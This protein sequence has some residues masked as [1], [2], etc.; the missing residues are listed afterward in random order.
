MPVAVVPREV[1]LPSA[2]V[3]YAHCVWNEYRSRFPGPLVILPDEV[4]NAL[5]VRANRGDHELIRQAVKQ[6]DVRP[7]QVLIEVLIVEARSDRG[8]SLGT[9]VSVPGQPLSGGGTAGGSLRGPISAGNTVL[10]LM[11]LGKEK[12]DAVLRVAESSGRV[13]IVSRPVLIASNNVEARLL[14]GAQ[15]PFVQ[16]TRALPTEAAVRDQVVQYR[17]VG[18]KLTIR[19]TINQDGF[20]TLQVRQEINAATAEVQFDAPVISTREASTQ[21]LARDGQTIVIGGLRDEQRERS[22]AG[23]PILSGIPLLGGLFGGQSRRSTSVELFLFLTPRIIASDDD[24][25]GVT[26]PRLPEGVEP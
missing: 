13:R 22:R 8:F 15:R 20:V 25:R 10:Q 21:V 6:L 11:D 7:L 9:E 19:P 2:S 26:T 23:V 24:V 12:I 17:D 1:R 4:T 14:V 5:L 3:V 16:V 18:T